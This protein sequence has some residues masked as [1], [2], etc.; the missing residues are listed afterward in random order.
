M[1]KIEWIDDP[2]D[3]AMAALKSNFICYHTEEE[4]QVL[5]QK[6]EAILAAPMEEMMS[7][8]LTPLNID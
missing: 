4:L 5:H 1:S 2:M 3:A 7:I 8:K 6:M